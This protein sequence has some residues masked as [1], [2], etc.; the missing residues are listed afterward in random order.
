[1]VITNRL[2]I[3]FNKRKLFSLFFNYV[4]LWKEIAF[5]TNVTINFL[6]LASYSDQYECE[7]QQAKDSFLGVFHEFFYMFPDGY[8]NDQTQFDTLKEFEDA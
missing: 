4:D 3:F 6:I 5:Y 7:N 1:M 8:P 2:R